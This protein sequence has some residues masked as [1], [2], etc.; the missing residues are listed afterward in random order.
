LEDS[1][2]VLWYIHAVPHRQ[3]ELSHQIELSKS[4]FCTYW[5][6]RCSAFNGCLWSICEESRKPEARCGLF[7]TFIIHHGYNI[8]QSC[9]SV[10][11]LSDHRAVL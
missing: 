5:C 7:S 4:H 11:L 3:K 9:S 8:L 1:Y 6:L 10:V 2:T